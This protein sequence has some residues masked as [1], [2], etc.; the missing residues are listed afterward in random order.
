MNM[1]ELLKHESIDD[2][3]LKI[4]RDDITKM[5]TQA[6]AED[7]GSGEEEKL[8]NFYRNSL[9]LSR[10][11]GS[12]AV[13]L[14]LIEAGSSGYPREEGL[15]IAVDEINDFLRRGDLDVTLV[16]PD[17]GSAQP[18]TKIYPDLEEYI[19]R[20]YADEERAEKRP[21]SSAKKL[22]D[23]SISFDSAMMSSAKASMVMPMEAD[24]EEMAGAAFEEECSFSEAISERIEHLEDPFGVYLLY[25][26]ESK[27]KTNAEVYGKA[28]ISKQ[29]F[30]KLKKNPK[31]Y[32][33]DKL[34]ALQ[35]CVGCELNIDETKD[36]LARAGYALSPADKRDIIFSYFITH[37]AYDMIDID[38]ALEEHGIPCIIK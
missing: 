6:F 23:L 14:P 15:R 11:K 22:C 3:A 2:M 7:A 24:V 4:I 5:S 25:L 8:R 29:S 33:P 27:G 20:N 19:D 38:I 17:K 10:E 26:I 31:E 35:Y 36:L 34:T 1:T 37:E 30:A 32:H 28:I 16:V 9:M 21:R 13:T 18:G 12:A